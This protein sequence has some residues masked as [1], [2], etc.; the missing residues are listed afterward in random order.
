[1]QTIPGTLKKGIIWKLFSYVCSTQC[2]VY[3]RAYKTF[4]VGGPGAGALLKWR[5]RLE[6]LVLV[7]VA[8]S[9]E[10]SCEDQLLRT[11]M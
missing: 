9:E 5:R 6:L 10:L 7:C 1:M 11:N 2:V 4:A 3:T 8:I